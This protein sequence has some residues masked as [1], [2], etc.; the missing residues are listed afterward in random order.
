MN[1]DGSFTV[2]VMAGLA[3]AV[4]S[5]L[6]VTTGAVVSIVIDKGEESGDCAPLVVCLAV[7]TWAPSASV[8]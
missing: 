7:M 2:P 4:E 5:E 8:V 6:T 1:A 3:D